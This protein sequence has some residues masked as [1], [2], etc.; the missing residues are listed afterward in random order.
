MQDDQG[1]QEARGQESA[2]AEMNPWLIVG[3][4]VALGV[5]TVTGYMRGDTAGRAAIQQQW[6]A[7]RTQQAEAHAMALEAARNKEQA[8]QASADQLRKEKDREIRDLNSR[9]AALTNSLRVRP[10]R[11]APQ[12]STV[13]AAASTG[14]AVAVCTGAELPR[15]DA[16]FL[17]REAARA[18]ELRAALKQCLTQ[19]QAVRQ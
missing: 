18:D 16:E 1:P 10:E 3:F 7:E 9:A 14:P 5:A 4:V 15:P 17:A 12:S 2:G 8:M 11:P 6:D 19:Y 13:P